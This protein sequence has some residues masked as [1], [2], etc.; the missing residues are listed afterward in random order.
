MFDLDDI[1]MSG[2][3]IKTD[4]TESNFVFSMNKELE[5]ELTKEIENKIEVYE[6]K[7]RLLGLIP[8]QFKISNPWNIVVKKCSTQ[9]TRCIIPDFVTTIGTGAFRDCHI[10]ELVIPDSV[11]SIESFAF[12]GCKELTKIQLSK[13][14]KKI[15]HNSFERC[16]NIQHIE[17]GEELEVI[18]EEA[19]RGCTELQEVQ[20]VGNINNIYRMAFC[21]CRELRSVTI[22]T[23]RIKL[24]KNMFTGC[25]KLEQI[26]LDC[27]TL[28][29]SGG[30]SYDTNAEVV[31]P[32]PIRIV[33]E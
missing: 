33:Q 24:G 1:L 16:S 28:N 19:F 23:D 14:L 6:S 25:Y 4:Y 12:M 30:F 9:A 29:L 22:S 13:S 17:F 32:N 3:D 18:G 5:H 7:C 21:D 2:L 15:G 27:K 26:V 20:L 8:L 31:I 11:T 10:A